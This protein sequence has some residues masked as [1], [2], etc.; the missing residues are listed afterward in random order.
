MVISCFRKF[1]ELHSASSIT[2]H[3]TT[4]ASSL[5]TLC[6]ISYFRWA[7]CANEV[8]FGAIQ[9]FS[10]ENILSSAEEEK[11]DP[12][13][14]HGPAGLILEVENVRKSIVDN[15][16]EEFAQ[17]GKIL[18]SFKLIC[19]EMFFTVKFFHRMLFMWTIR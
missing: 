1:S 17:Y 19:T 8:M 18:V 6:S 12:P 13:I 4:C 11:E 3:F 5:L 15:V 7:G 9:L 14:F 10:V 16:R 2:D